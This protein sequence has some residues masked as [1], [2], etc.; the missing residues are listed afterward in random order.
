[1]EGE[2]APKG[3]AR[4]YERGSEE[5]TRTLALSDG[6]FAIAMTLLVVTIALPTLRDG[7]SASELL[8]VL[9]DLS[10][11]VIS[12]FIS[13]A[14]IARYWVAHQKQF[15]M[16][17]RMDRP[18]IGLNLVYLAFIALLP[19][20]T[21]LLGNYFE[22][23]ISVTVYAITVGI[24]SG[25]EVVLFVYAHRN[26][27]LATQLP[28]EVYRW[29]VRQASAPL[30]FFVISIPVAFV[31]TTIAVVLWFGAVPLGLAG[32]RSKPAQADAY[33]G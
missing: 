14:V 13:F 31:S 23:P 7:G 2:G 16:L 30:A 19:F 18:F 25:M 4:T 1:M 24:V 33:L 6:V 12:F 11:S 21:D 10:P 20:P 22:N 28:E 5:F 9:N 27:L 8:D 32:N 3:V 15:S 29:G 26:R 17:V